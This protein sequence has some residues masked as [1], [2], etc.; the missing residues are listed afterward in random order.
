MSHKFIL[1]IILL[2]SSLSNSETLSNEF[3]QDT[4]QGFIELFCQDGI[5]RHCADINQGICSSGVKKAV[6]SCDSRKLEASIDKAIESQTELEKEPKHAQCLTAA[7]PRHLEVETSLFEECLS[8]R[9]QRKLD[10]VRQER[11]NKA[12][13][14]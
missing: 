6:A 8:A 10:S 7:F 14:E 9:F 3:D 12:P 11:G 13:A 4:A 1:M 5:F 2:G